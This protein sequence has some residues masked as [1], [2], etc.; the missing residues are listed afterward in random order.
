M[1]PGP[2]AVALLCAAFLRASAETVPDRK[3]AVLKD[4]ATLEKDPRWIY[5]DS[6]RAFAEAKRTGKPVLAVLRCIPCLACAGID[7]QVLLDNPDLTPL[8][9]Q[10]VCVRII[11]ANTLD[12]ARFQF[13]FDLSFSAMI[14]NADGTLYGRYGS[15]IHQKDPREQATDGFRRSLQAALTLH[16]GYPANR[17]ALQP[18]QPKPTAYKT[19]VDMPT[20]QGKYGRNLDWEGKVVQS[21]V[22]CHQIG[23]ALRASFRDRKEPIPS[24]LV[25]P[26]PAPEAVGIELALDHTA[27]VK[28]VAQGSV[29]DKAG[30][31][32]G[33]DILSLAGQPLISSADLSWALHHAAES[34]SL[35]L[36]IA[37]G[38]RTLSKTLSL[39]DG[40]RAQSD[41]SRRVG[42]WGMRAMALGGMLLE[43]LS[44]AERERR[45]VGVSQLALFAKHVGEYGEHAAAKKA[46]FKKEDVIVAL[47]GVTRRSSEGQIIGQM[48][49]TH[50]PGDTVKATV[51]RGTERIELSFP[52]Q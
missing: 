45:G 15:W 20:I 37:R 52:M 14:F 32:A 39:P 40:W 43:D 1:K 48:L 24:N 42:T 16:K 19:P 6:D 30:L 33:D 7:A 50:K 29:A 13:D 28:T 18:K 17:T 9:D 49:R 31:R 3:G 4:R 22:H 41:I 21:C 36:S 23:D 51:L 8:L 46:G 25:F 34:G 44:D 10:F 27:R 11:N 26:F 47:D 5:N 2:I 12:L 38:T 35:R